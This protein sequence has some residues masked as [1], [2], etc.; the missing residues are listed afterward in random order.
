M[1]RLKGGHLWKHV[2]NKQ[3]SS[4]QCVLSCH[5]SL[6]AGNLWCTN[7]LYINHSQFLTKFQSCGTYNWLFCRRL[8]CVT[9]LRA[10]ATSIS[11]AE[12]SINGVTSAPTGCR[13]SA[14]LGITYQ[15]ARLMRRPCHGPGENSS[16]NAVCFSP[17]EGSGCT[18]FSFNMGGKH[19]GLFVILKPISIALDA[20][21]LCKRNI[22]SWLFPND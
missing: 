14:S 12:R 2:E 8:L 6:N 13:C 20:A 10:L 11:P 5:L 21:N 3:T 19:S 9:T 7:I 4:S 18:I 15:R 22:A 17:G 1:F 16:H